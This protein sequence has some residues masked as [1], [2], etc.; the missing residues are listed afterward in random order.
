MVTKGQ[1]GVGSAERQSASSPMRVLIAIDGSAASDA[2]IDLAE[3]LAWP[4]GSTI[5]VLEVTHPAPV[6]ATGPWPTSVP[7]ETERIIAEARKSARTTV[8]EAVRRLQGP[9][10]TIESTVLD[11][12][13]ATVILDRAAT[14]PADL[15]IIGSRG[16]GTLG[17]M[18]V[19]SVSS[20]VID[21]AS[22]PVLV[23][24]SNQ[25]ER[26][27][28]AADGSDAVER[29]AEL[30]TAWPIF[31]DATVRVVSVAHA[32]PPWWTGF[33]P[34]PTGRAA[35]QVT[36]EPSIDHHKRLAHDMAA[37]LADAGYAVEPKVRQGDAASEIVAEARD[38]DA[39]LV[40]MGTR[41]RG[42]VPRLLLGSTAR[43]VLHNV[44]CSVLVAH[45]AGA[46]GEAGPA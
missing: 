3:K 41:G 25:A 43:N 18:L 46:R 19:G 40:M 1:P 13:A 5:E 34:S 38:W 26:I 2:T 27:V 24:H 21:H 42:G 15:I 7:I 17:S 20:E 45:A 30:L 28:L 31:G 35:E 14:L 9:D 12:R 4:A 36:P 16:H 44:G 23:A 37:R 39:D 10:R 29:V 32:D 6:Y 33:R 11:G 8:E 22:V